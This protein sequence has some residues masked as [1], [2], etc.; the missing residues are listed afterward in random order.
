M[1]DSTTTT[2]PTLSTTTKTTPLTDSTAMTETTETTTETTSSSTITYNS[3]T[4]KPTEA[5]STST[6]VTETSTGTTPDD[7]R[8]IDGNT[9]FWPHPRDCNKYI[10]CYQG[11]SYEMACPTNTYFSDEYKKCTNADESEC[12]KNNSSQCK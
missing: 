12:C 5:T 9:S 7:P 11:D 6:P 10:E 1:T 2:T 4:T 3:R 8:C